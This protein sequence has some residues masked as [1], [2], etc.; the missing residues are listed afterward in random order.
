MMNNKRGI[1]P[2][3]ATVLLVAIVII[4][5]L[6]IYFWYSNVLIKQT[7]KEQLTSELICAQ[8]IEF[9]LKNIGCSIPLNSSDPTAVI[10]KA[11]NTGS[12]HINKFQVVVRYNDGD[13]INVQ[14]GTGVNYPETEQ[15]SAEVPDL[16]S[17]T[18][19]DIEVTP[20]I[21]NQGTAKECTEQMKS[22]TY[23]C[24]TP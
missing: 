18:V 9:E 11:T 1:S 5:G 24:P 21:I 6:L 8:K 19:L 17:G 4:I 7:E 3:V 14:T 22:A 2:L 13:V 12:A 16:I 20:I 15:L 23:T 10:F